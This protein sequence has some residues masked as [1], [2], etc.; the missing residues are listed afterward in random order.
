MRVGIYA[1]VSTNDQHTLPMQLSQMKDYIKNR[2]W[3]LTVEV[4]EVGSGA[5]NSPKTRRTFENGK[6]ARN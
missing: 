6:T 2:N 1:R 3:T 5:K 4:E